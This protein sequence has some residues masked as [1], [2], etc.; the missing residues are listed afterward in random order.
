VDKIT[1][2]AK[3]HN[4]L[5]IEDDGRGLF[6]PGCMHHTMYAYNALFYDMEKRLEIWA[7]KGVFKARF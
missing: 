4:A 7:S 5:I 2:D 3:H 1:H 6:V